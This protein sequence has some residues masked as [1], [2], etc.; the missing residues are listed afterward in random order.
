M[1]QTQNLCAINKKRHLRLKDINISIRQ[2]EIVGVAGVEGNGQLELEEV[3]MGLREIEQ[4]K[5][6]VKNQD[7]TTFSTAQRR[8]LGMAHIPSDRLKR[9]TIPAFE[10]EKN[11]RKKEKK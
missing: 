2:G 1:L 10:L 5:I 9:G 7:I 4:G 3:L 8:A 6:T 11:G